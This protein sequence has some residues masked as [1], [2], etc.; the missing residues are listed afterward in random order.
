[1]DV[2]Q[3]KYTEWKKP[4]VKWVYL[5]SFHLHRILKNENEPLVIES[6]SMTTWIWGWGEGREGFLKAQETFQGDADVH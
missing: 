4:E 6:R 3:N 5:I 2:S 1:M